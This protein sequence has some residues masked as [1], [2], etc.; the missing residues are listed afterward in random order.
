MH[1]ANCRFVQCLVVVGNTQG[2]CMLIMIMSIRSLMLRITVM[3]MMVA[4]W[5][6]LVI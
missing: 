2:F 5:G 1:A 3:I 4:N 6:L